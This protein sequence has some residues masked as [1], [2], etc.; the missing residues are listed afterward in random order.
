MS[1]GL[2]PVMVDGRHKPFWT[3]ALTRSGLAGF[4]AMLVVGLTLRS[5]RAVAMGSLHAISICKIKSQYGEIQCMW[6]ELEVGDIFGRG[7][8]ESLTRASPNWR[9]ACNVG[10][11]HTSSRCRRTRSKITGEYRWDAVM[12]LSKLPEHWP[13]LV[14]LRIL[15]V[16][17]VCLPASALG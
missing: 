12:V 7:Q 13:M 11:G 17:T 14:S 3:V 8:V 16:A 2:F 1:A 15:V 6:V 4:V 9:P 5:Q 10:Y